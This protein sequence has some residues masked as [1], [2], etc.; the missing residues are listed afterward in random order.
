MVSVIEG[1][2][3]QG[4][5][6]VTYGTDGEKVRSWSWSAGFLVIVRQLAGQDSE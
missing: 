1:Q 4:H 5:T 2:C 6:Y 3:V